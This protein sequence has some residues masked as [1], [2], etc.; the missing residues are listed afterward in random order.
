MKTPRKA[1]PGKAASSKTGSP[2][3]VLASESKF[4]RRALDLLGLAYETCPSRIDEKSIR[5]DDPAQLTRKLAEAKA[6]RV[7]EQYAADRNK[8]RA[9]TPDIYQDVVIVSGDA[10]VAK[11]G[12]IYEKPRDTQESAQFLGELSGSTFQFVTALAVLH[13]RTRKLLSA[14][15][16]SDLTFRPLDGR[17]IQSY[18]AAY[19]VTSYAGA[20]ESDAVLRFAERISGSYN[21]VTALPV[22]RLILFL[23]AQG[24]AI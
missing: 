7:A 24:V 12:R 10:V 6:W 20:F 11:A 21:F 4:R 2:K 9:K 5:A 18:I 15:E 8:H 23:R 1:A 3:I 22:S 13:S 17:E 19:N 16:T 14:V